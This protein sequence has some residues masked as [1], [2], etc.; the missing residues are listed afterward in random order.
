MS[1]DWRAQAA[2][3]GEDPELFF[4]VVEEGPLCEDQIAAA[5]AVC[6]RCPVRDACLEWSTTHIHVG[7]AGGLTAEE[8]RAARAESLAPRPGRIR[9]PSPREDIR[10]AGLALLKRGESNQDVA[11]RCGV[12]DRTVERWRAAISA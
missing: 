7:I 11:V 12:T 6:G 8:R 2:C 3:V 9:Q 10:A 1:A 5:K 4:P